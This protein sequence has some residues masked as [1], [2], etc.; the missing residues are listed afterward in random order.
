MT[1]FVV[2]NEM[3]CANAT[4]PDFNNFLS[5]KSSIFFNESLNVGF[6]NRN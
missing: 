3:N 6:Q 5:Y 1:Q 2:N 4:L